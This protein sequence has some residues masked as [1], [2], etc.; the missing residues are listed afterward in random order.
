MSQKAVD[1][2]R[3]FTRF[4]TN[5]MGVLD[6]HIL[7][8]PFSLSQARVLYELN[9]TENCTARGIMQSLKIDEGYL[10]RI[11]D[12]FIQQGLIKK[13]PSETDKRSKVLTVTSKGRAAF[14][15][16]NHASAQDVQKIIHKLSEKEIDD[17]V[18][19]M[20]TIQKILSQSK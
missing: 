19:S 5:A 11:L 4:Y 8:S 1:R 17:L 20:Q 15:K 9:N 7:D 10:S 3:N 16:I 2:I 13:T 6:K 14:Q 12:T 18:T